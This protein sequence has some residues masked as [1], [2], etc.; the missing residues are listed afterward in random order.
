MYVEASRTLQHRVTTII[1]EKG[2]LKHEKTFGQ[3]G[4]I[5]VIIITSYY[6][7]VVIIYTISSARLK[8]K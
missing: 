7:I 5:A 1:I 3:N 8:Y 2:N 6:A 4:T